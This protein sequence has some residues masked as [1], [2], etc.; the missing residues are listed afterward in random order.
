[1]AANIKRVGIVGYGRLGQY[2]AKAV[3]DRP[4]ELALAFVWNRYE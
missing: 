2:L 3:L 4:N 1:M